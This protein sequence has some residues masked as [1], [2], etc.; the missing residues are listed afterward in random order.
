[1]LD[2]LELVQ[3]QEIGTYDRR[4]LAEHKPPGMEGSLLQNLGR[5][6]VRLSLWG[7]ATGEEAMQFI[8]KLQEKF[9]AGAPVDFIADIIADAEI[10]KMVIDDLQMQDLAGKPDRYAYVLTLRE[11]IEP[12]EP[13]DTAVLDA[14]ILEDAAGLIDDLV[15][16][17]DAAQAF[18]SGLEQ[19]TSSLTDIMARLQQ[20]RQDVEK[21]KGG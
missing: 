3:V 6:P 11:F 10:E 8:E 21:A 20:F 18:A 4:V 1:M 2:D 12:K 5:R 14:S 17:L 19:F 15:N 7:V 9:R 13:E 16:G